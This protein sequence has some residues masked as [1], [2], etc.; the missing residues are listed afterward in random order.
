MGLRLAGLI[1]FPIRVPCARVKNYSEMLRGDGRTGLG[2]TQK[3]KTWNSF[4]LSKSIFK[5]HYIN[6]KM[7][8]FFL[9][10]FPYTTYVYSCLLLSI[11]KVHYINLR[12]FGCSLNLFPDTT[13]KLERISALT[14]FN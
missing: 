7:F 11:F 10:L 14:Q 2:S 9:N 1:A 4:T 12:I 13:Y 5:V 6:L 3:K 8:G